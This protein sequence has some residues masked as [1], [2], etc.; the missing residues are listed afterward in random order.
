MAS[1][2]VS[3]TTVAS[4]QS[5]WLARRRDAYKLS[6]RDALIFSFSFSRFVVLHGVVINLAP[7]YSAYIRS[8]DGSHV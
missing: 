8:A 7:K 6:R 2:S 3:W 5:V 1:V 4:G